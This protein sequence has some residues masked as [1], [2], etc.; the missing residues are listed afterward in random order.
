[1]VAEAPPL[2]AAP[3]CP[4]LAHLRFLPCLVEVVPSSPLLRLLA[5]P[6]VLG[7]QAEAA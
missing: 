1:M 4:P 3:L 2:A 7:P 6:L 5:E